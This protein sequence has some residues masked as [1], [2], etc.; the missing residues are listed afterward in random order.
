MN[1]EALR[2]LAERLATASGAVQ[3]VLFGSAA[4]GGW[5]EGSDLDLLLILPDDADP[6]AAMRRAQK[7]LFPRTVPLDL[8]PMRRSHWLGKHSQLARTAVEEGVVLYGD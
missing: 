2:T 1:P 6:G 5:R 4:R 3:V 7:A 8:V